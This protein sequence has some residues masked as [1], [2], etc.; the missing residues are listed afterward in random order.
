MKKAN[1]GN[2][3]L[4]FNFKTG[5]S[6]I[7]DGSLTK[8]QIMQKHN[9][10]LLIE[11]R[12]S[13]APSYLLIKTDNS[14]TPNYFLAKTDNSDNHDYVGIKKQIIQIILIVR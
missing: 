13:D 3:K 2:P 6:K 1:P 4:L 14:D 12:T 5:K 10:Y 8:K 9:N 11:N 7:H